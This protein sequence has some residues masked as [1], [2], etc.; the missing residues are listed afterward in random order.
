[1]TPLEL[2]ISKGNLEITLTLIHRGE[3]PKGD[4]EKTNAFRLAV[5][6]GMLPIVELLY[7]QCST[8]VREEALFSSIYRNKPAI[9]GYLIQQGV[10]INATEQN[11]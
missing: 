7:P 2:S 1:M 10:S 9:V 6:R 5:G 3:V 11:T 8:T 4:I